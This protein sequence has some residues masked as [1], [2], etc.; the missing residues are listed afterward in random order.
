MRINNRYKFA[1]LVLVILSILSFFIGF[2]YGE[3]SAG[4]GSL[5]GDFS[6]VWK[7]L[8]TFLNNDI[9]A[10]LKF[11]ADFDPENFYMSGRTP[12]LYIFHKLFNPFVE[13]KTIFIRS[14]FVLSLSAPV[15]FYLCLRQKFKNE[16]SL[17]LILIS[18]TICLSPYFRTSSYWGL[19]ENYGLICLLLTFLFLSQFLSSNNLSWKN[20][21]QLFLTTFFSS[22][23]LYFD[24][25]LIIIPLIC[26]FQILFSD[27]TL[28]LKILLFLF[29]F[30]FSLPYIY[31]AT[32]WGNIIPSLSAD[33]RGT[34]NQLYLEHLGYTATIIAFYLFPLLLYKSGNFFDLFKNFFR[35]RKNYY[36]ISLFFIYLLYLLIFYDYDSEVKL[37]K[38]F[39]HKTA[40]LLFKENY[41][42]EIFIYF[43]F[44]V[45][46]LI[47]LIY[48][49]DNLQDKLII[50]YFFLLSI[51]VWPILQ[52]Y[53]DPLI[54]LM[55]FTFFNSKLIINYERSILFFLYLSILLIFSNIY[56]YN[57]LN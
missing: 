38:G 5:D 25:K 51:I 8:Q 10:A 30:I 34:G 22:L 44:F 15:L 4:A 27:K 14:V 39:I 43:S 1:S 20:Y 26:F 32:I 2:I 3:N 53:F 40:I 28:K 9:V 36:L 21:Y 11:T 48:L 16:E 18:T 31:L 45:S 46:W 56:Y 13:S 7:N 19:E 23:C 12:L 24:Q 41:L 37:G 54:I 55:A 33:V 47:I 17:L 29:Y 6:N 52:E 42:Q 49:N 35:V 50:F 57:L